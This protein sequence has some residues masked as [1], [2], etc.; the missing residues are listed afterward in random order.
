M[1]KKI[2]LSLLAVL[3]VITC[4]TKISDYD[5]W[6]HLALGEEVYQQGHLYTFDK[7]S[8]TF[9]GENQFTSEWFANLLIYL[10]YHLGGLWGTNIL[11]VFIII[12]SF[13]F[14]FLTLKTISANKKT[15]LYAFIITL[16]FLLF[17]IRFRLFIRPYIF[18]YLFF[19]VFIFILAHYDKNKKFRILYLLPLIEL[20]WANISVGA[21]FGPILLAFFILGNTVKNGNGILRLLVLLA[22]TV[23]SA[24]INPDTYKIYYLPLSALLHDPY[25]MTLGEH[26]PI[27]A[28]ILWGYGLRYTFGYQILFLGAAVYLLLLK[29]WRNIYYLITFLAFFIVSLFHVRMI[30]F[31]SFFACTLFFMATNRLLEKIEPL[32]LSKKTLLDSIVFGSLLLIAFLVAG[33]KTYAFG[34]GTKENQFPEKALSFLK[35]E[36]LNVRIFNSYAYGGY[37][38]WSAPEYKVFID[39]RQRDL[40]SPEFYNAYFEM[41]H[42]AKSWA[43]AEQ[44]WMFDCAILDYDL[45]DRRFPLHLNNNPN[46]SVVYWDNSSAVYLKKTTDNL[47]TINKYEYKITKPNFYDFSY[48]NRYLQ[49][50]E[51]A[52]SALAQ[53]DKEIAINPSNQEPRLAKV[54]LLYNLGKSYWDEAKKE[55]LESHKLKPDLAIEHSAYAIFLFEE[56]NTE[57]ALTELKK[58]ISIDP[59][60]PASLYLTKKYNPKNLR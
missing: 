34:I 57:P 5:F 33:S 31:F 27:T 45:K 1:T 19:S 15:E 12:L 2:I 20:L 30:D 38:M 22:V 7:F 28:Q 3:V 41:L 53:I 54:L 35:K 23:I 36:N 4:I 46:W 24:V 40:Y 58:A 37:I 10:S 42:N 47:Q 51:T 18:S 43:L 9:Q 14:I 49:S 13:V 16:L 6:W 8:Y 25:K 50:K 59:Y 44:K 29:G 56:G 52:L 48:V 26:Q 21:I 39:G 60:D 17:S 32:I 55:L 11:K